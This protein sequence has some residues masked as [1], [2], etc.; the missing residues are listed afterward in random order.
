MHTRHFPPVPEDHGFDPRDRVEILGLE[1]K[2]EA[3]GAF[4]LDRDPLH[5]PAMSV[6]SWLRKAAASSGDSAV[7]CG[8]QA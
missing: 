4:R 5:D 6:R 2:P 3:I 7:S 1:L 8:E